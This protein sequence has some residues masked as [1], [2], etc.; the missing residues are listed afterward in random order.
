M[1]DGSTVHVRP[2]RPD[3]EPGLLAFLRALSEPSRSL[4]FFSPAVNL[5][6]EAQRESQVDP[7]RS[8]GLVATA[9]PEGRVVGH[10]SYEI[11]THDR[12]E[13]AFA[14]ADEYQGRGMGTI[15]LGH[16]AE[17]AASSGIQVFEAWV[18]PTNYQML[19]VFRKSGFRVEVRTLP[20]ALLVTFP[21]SLTEEAIERFDRREQIAAV[22]ALQAFLS[23]RSIAV[24]G[25]SRQR[26]TV[27]GEVFHNLLAGEFAG[28][29]YPVNPA[30]EVVQSVS[31]YPTVEAIPGPIDLAVVA[32]PA[33]QVPQ[34]AEQCGRKGVRAL[35]VL[36]AGFSE[37]GEPG[38]ARQAELVR[39]CRAAGMRLIGPN[40][41]GVA[42]TD[43]AVRLNATFGPHVPLPGRIGFASQSGALGLA[44]IDYAGARGLGL[45]SFVSLGN[46]AD[47]S[48]N[49]L[50]NY[51]ESD[52]R[53]DV[54]LLY[55]ES[56]GNPRKFSRL[57]RRV[58]RHKPIAV[59]KS[60]RSAAG[61]RAT[62]SH[63]GALLAASDVT[64]DALFRQAGVI[65]TDT[66]DQLFDVASL[67]AYQPLPG[68]RRVGIVTNV[69]GPA[70][71]CVDACVA[72]GLEVPVLAEATQARLRQ[73]LPAEASVANP[74]DMLAPAT[75]EQYR[76]AIGLVAADPN[77]DA[78]IALFIPPLAT[79]GGDVASAIADAARALERPTPLLAVFMWSQGGPEELKTPE[80]CIPS[81]AFPESAALA[82][83]HAVRHSVWRQRPFVP[84]PRLEGLRRD[85]AA[86]LVAEA[87][88]RGAGWLEPAEVARLLACY[89]LP[90]VEQRTVATPEEAGAAAEALGGEVA[91]K[92][93]APGLVHKTEAGAVRL[94]LH[95]SEAVCQAAQEMAARLAAA[96]RP[97]TAFLVQPMVPQ[98]VELLVGIVHDPQFGPVLACGAGGV[99][100]E[101]LK[102]MAV[103]LTPLGREAA[104]EMLRELNTYPL[105]EGYRGGPARD[106]P[107]L[108]EVLVRVSALAEDLPQIAELDCN[109][110]L[111][112]ERGAA[113]VDA[114]VRVEP[115]RPPLPLGARS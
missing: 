37:I 84:P 21:T 12:A 62:A 94:R 92:A 56:L 11:L 46:K 44:A 91:L 31:A 75:A 47:L 106:V 41:L 57:A 43:P 52:P 18:L 27:G 32:V 40:C 19:D 3:D 58:G 34:V 8:F 5:V 97:P 38:R 13:V 10:A 78:V 29:V 67:L 74:V 70:I 77:V 85:E 112:L 6:A 17:V 82:L 114:R 30:A 26:G 111:A 95:G 4:R 55:L 39:V 20:D 15:L 68:G 23:P 54:I 89:G 86:A 101:L 87:L 7:T 16:L 83:A 45:S 69:G 88:G 50:L 60:G 9:G 63:T 80:V 71:L 64:V 98:G 28:P 72:E 65:R 100:A 113:I 48:G 14:I 53:T 24:I 109:P 2:V 108:E 59:V 99:L 104:R 115:A 36:S 73:L 107:A 90:L 93:I 105:L 110:V 96:G 102:D 42:N 22:N 33:A 49:D 66:L 25:A 1:R 79:C 81:Y 76:R 61:A 51:W 35:L 103:R